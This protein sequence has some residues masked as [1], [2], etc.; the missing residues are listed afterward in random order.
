MSSIA[1]PVPSTLQRPPLGRD[2][3]RG[4]HVNADREPTAPAAAGALPVRP[5][6]RAPDGTAARPLDRTE[7]EALAVEISRPMFATALSLT[8]RREEAED[9]VQ[10]ALYRGWRSVATFERGSNFRGWMFRI[11]HNVFTNRWHREQRAPKAVDPETL[12]P[13]APDAPLPDVRD[14]GSFDAVADAHLDD[15]VKHAVDGIPVVYREPFLLFSLGE[16]SY[17]EIAAA[18]DIPIGTVMSRLHRARKLLRESLL[19]Y[20]RERRHP[21]GGAS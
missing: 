10:E 18:L 4:T 1:P 20:A 17:A 12:D 6:A 3:S 19:G 2:P 11:L 16:L 8:R 5:A 14:L 15:D 7:F 9:V 21:S 13:A